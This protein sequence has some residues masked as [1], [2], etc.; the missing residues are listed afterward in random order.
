MGPKKKTMVVVLVF[1]LLWLVHSLESLSYT[2]FWH[3]KSGCNA[4]ILRTNKLFYS[5]FIHDLTSAT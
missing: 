4:G 1:N 3:Y 5:C 2:V